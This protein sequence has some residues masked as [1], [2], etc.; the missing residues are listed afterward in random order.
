MDVALGEIV[1]GRDPLKAKRG[2]RVVV[3]INVPLDGRLCSTVQSVAGCL[4]QLQ[5]IERVNTVRSGHHY[6]QTK[7]GLRYKVAYARCRKHPRKGH[8]DSDRSQ[9]GGQDLHDMLA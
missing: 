3:L 2:R 4:E 7:S 5:A 9:P 1:I 8:V 6:A